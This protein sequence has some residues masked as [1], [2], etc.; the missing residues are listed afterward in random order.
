MTEEEMKRL[1]EQIGERGGWE[2]VNEDDVLDPNF[3]PQV[4]LKPCTE[5]R[6]KEIAKEEVEPYAKQIRGLQY[7][8]LE[9]EK[10]VSDWE[11]ITELSPNNPYTATTLEYLKFFLSEIERVMDGSLADHYER[12]EKF[13]N[14]E[15][16]K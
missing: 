4:E 7:L 10:L 3:V 13:M 9:V 5:E 2:I 12:I 1:N 11:K 15:E 8:K 6:A 14:D 16:K